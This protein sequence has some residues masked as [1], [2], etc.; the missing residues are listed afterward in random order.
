MS[1]D[2]ATQDTTGL[3]VIEPTPKLVAQVYRAIIEGEVPPEIGDPGI[4]AKAIQWR[5][6]QGTFDDSMDWQSQLP[7]LAET[8]VYPHPSLEKTKVSGP[9]L[10]HGFHLNPSTIENPEGD[11]GVYAVVDATDLA[12]GERDTYSAG[13]G[14]VLVQLAKAWEEGKYPF[15]GVFAVATTG[16][17]RSTHWLKRGLSEA[18]TPE[19]ADA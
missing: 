19:E 9:M 18:G 17:G 7:P 6:A 2:L 16:Q 11:K 4:T 13:G 14:N 3:A 1:Q 5:V 10:F 15:E 12:T 8:A